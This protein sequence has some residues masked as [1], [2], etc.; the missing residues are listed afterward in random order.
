MKVPN[1]RLKTATR[2]ENKLVPL[3]KQIAAGLKPKRKA[4]TNG[5]KGK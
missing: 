2:A 1:K 5:P 3:H 4:I